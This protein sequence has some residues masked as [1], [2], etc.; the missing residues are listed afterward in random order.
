LYYTAYNSYKEILEG[1][2]QIGIDDEGKITG[3]VLTH[4]PENPTSVPEGFKEAME[5]FYSKRVD[6]YTA[7]LNAAKE[8]QEDYANSLLYGITIGGTNLLTGSESMRNVDWESLGEAVVDPNI[9]DAEI[10]N[11]EAISFKVNKTTDNKDTGGTSQYKVQLNL[12][13]SSKMSS[14]DK[15]TLSVYVKRKQGSS[16]INIKTNL[17]KSANSQGSD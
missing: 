17:R 16:S 7:L 14:E 4:D 6:V 1:I 2:L 5:G 15:Y 12:Y 8:Y 11:E 13:D 9:E 3:P 10:D